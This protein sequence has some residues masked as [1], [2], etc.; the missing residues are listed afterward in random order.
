M[1]KNVSFGYQD[2]GAAGL[3][4]RQPVTPY[5]ECSGVDDILRAYPGTVARKTAF[6]LF[7]LGYIEG[8][9]AER[10]RRKKTI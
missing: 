9:R 3:V 6:S 10:K 7:M 2:S 5:Y 4:L 1:G 8:K